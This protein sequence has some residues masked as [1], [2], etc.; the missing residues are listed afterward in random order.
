MPGSSLWLVPPED[1]D[2]YKAIDNLVNQRLPSIYTNASPKRFLP[3]VTLTSDTISNYADPQEWLD[4]ISLPRDDALASLV[5]TIKDVQVGK[6]FFRK[7][8]MACSKTFELCDLALHCRIAG[9][10]GVEQEVANNSDAS[11][12][13]VEE[14]LTKVNDAI[15]DAKQQCSNSKI[16][17]RGSIWLVPTFKAIEDWKPV[18]IRQ[19]PSMKWVWST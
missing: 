18:A 15:Q 9:V 13:H 14:K 1:S 5:V 17:T 6:P 19:L 4:S 8:T 16:T 2:L 10:E 12:D 7:L 3:H 11:E